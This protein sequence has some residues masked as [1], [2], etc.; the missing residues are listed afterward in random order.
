MLNLVFSSKIFQVEIIDFMHGLDILHIDIKPENVMVR[1]RENKLFM[2]GELSKDVL[3]NRKEL[4]LTCFFANK[5]RFG[6]SKAYK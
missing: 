1:Q 2:I 4:I 5:I 3:K 6:L